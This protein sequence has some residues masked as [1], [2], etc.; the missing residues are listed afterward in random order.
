MQS[1]REAFEYPGCPRGSGSLNCKKKKEENLFSSGA[2][3]GVHT[4]YPIAPKI[5]LGISSLTVSVNQ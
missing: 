5:R 4:G 2:A 1:E 3:A